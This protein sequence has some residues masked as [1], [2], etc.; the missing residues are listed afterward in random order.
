MREEISSA[1][2]AHGSWKVR[3][4]TAIDSGRFDEATE[5]GLREDNRCAFGRW[6][7]GK[8]IPE[9]ARTSAEY[10]NIRSLH[11]EFH[12]A[13]AAVVEAAKSGRKTEADEMMKPGGTFSLTSSDLIQA[14]TA[15][16]RTLS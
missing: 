6:L 11:A 4:K 7:Y 8:T 1:I 3:L 10:E 14:L 12:K 16:K 15:W 2:A 9:G 13:A 5:N